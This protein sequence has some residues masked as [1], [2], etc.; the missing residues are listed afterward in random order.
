MKTYLLTIP[1]AATDAAVHAALADLLAQHRIVLEADDAPTMP[2]LSAAEIADDVV[3]GLAQPGRSRAEA[4]V[5]LG[6]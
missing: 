6:Q 3:R 5:R 1:D 2:P 4:E